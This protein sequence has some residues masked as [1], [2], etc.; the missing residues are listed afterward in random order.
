M[1]AEVRDISGPP[2]EMFTYEQLPDA[3]EA[4]QRGDDIDY[5][6]AAGAVD[7]D[8]AGDATAGICSPV[9]VHPGARDDP[10][11]FPWQRPRKSS[12]RRWGKPHAA[13]IIG[14]RKHAS[15]AAAGRTKEAAR[16]LIQR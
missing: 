11:R 10:A 5:E 15:A 1:A 3:I 9:R 6:G 4:L 13:L 14:A 8:E 2:G 16:R 12:G 7:M